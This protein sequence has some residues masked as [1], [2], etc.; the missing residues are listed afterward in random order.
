MGQ[1]YGEIGVA[2][3]ISRD[4]F[5]LR[6]NRPDFSLGSR[7]HAATSSDTHCRHRERGMR[8][9]R[10]SGD[11]RDVNIQLRS[12]AVREGSPHDRRQIGRNTPVPNGNG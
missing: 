2:D 3:D 11:A 5:G 6:K 1:T 7:P 4:L 12:K 9:R 10:D 8:G